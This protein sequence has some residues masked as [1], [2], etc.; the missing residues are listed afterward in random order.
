MAKP[1][2]A[3]FDSYSAR[4]LAG[5]AT[6]YRLDLSRGVMRHSFDQLENDSRALDHRGDRRE[7][8]TKCCWRLAACG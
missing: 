3:E 6:G 8:V 1:F 5:K 4:W 7:R 2:L